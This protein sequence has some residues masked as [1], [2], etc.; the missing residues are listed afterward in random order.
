MTQSATEIFKKNVTS[1]N[2]PEFPAQF[3]KFPGIPATNSAHEN[4]LEFPHLTNRFAAFL[5]FCFLYV[6][7]WARAKPCFSY[8]I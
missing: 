5:I 7:G 2:S 6:Y 1:I 3:Q 8:I 4:C